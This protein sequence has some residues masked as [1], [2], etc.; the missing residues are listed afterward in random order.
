MKF[1]DLGR[2]KSVAI[3]LAAFMLLIG[4]VLG[5]NMYMSQLF[6]NDLSGV[7]YLSRQQVQPAVVV[8]NSHAIAARLKSHESIN[9]AFS[10]LRA[11]ATDIDQT[12]NSLANTATVTDEQGRMYSFSSMHDE[13]AAS[14]L[15][16][17]ARS[18]NSY[19]TK[20][21]VVLRLSGNPYDTD[22]SG[23]M[24]LNERGQRLAEALAAL[25]PFEE[26]VQKELSAAFKTV[27]EQLEA[28][29]KSRVGVLRLVQIAAIVIALGGLIAILSYLGGTLRS[30]EIQSGLA[31]KETTN[32][33]RTVNEGLFLLDRNQR[34]GSERSLAMA[35]IFRREDLDGMTFE[36]LLRNIVPEKTLKTAQDYVTLLWGE[37]VN[38][39][40][41]KTINPL[42]EVEVHFDNPAGG[43][44][45]H[46]L[47]FDFNRVKSDGQLTHLLVTVN[48][49]TKRVMLAR[50][51]QE[52]QEKAQAQL[53]LLLRI[54]HV[55][56][57]TLTGFLTDAET[58]LKMVNTI[59][60]EPAREE[61]VFRSKIDNI[62]R[63]IHAVKGE[64][65][66]LGLKTVEQRAHSFEESLSEIKSRTS[67]SGNDFLPLV[68]KLDDLFNH[69]AQ[70]REMLGR[71]VDLH[72]AIATRRASE[73]GTKTTQKTE[74][75]SEEVNDWLANANN[76]DPREGTSALESLMSGNGLK[77]TLDKLAQK[78][79]DNSAKQVELETTGLE[80]VPEAYRRAI[81][82]I[83]IQL[84]RNAVVHGIE[85]P[86]ERKGTNK[87]E[88][89]QLS[90]E[91]ADHGANGV[92]LT[93]KDDGRGLQLDR[94]KQ[95]AIERGLLSAGQAALLDQRQTMALI[96]R[97]GFSTADGVT[98]DA[99][100][101]A[102]M[103]LVR[104]VVAELNGRVGMSTAKGRYTKFK[105][106]LPPLSQA[107]VAA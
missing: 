47:E 51:L 19:K 91:F 34:I 26:K 21:D 71:L 60:R 7:K 67:I 57:S 4:L 99:G 25:T 16:S 49:V 76:D 96:F 77:R 78:V 6:S 72:Q 79:A 31:R 9:D 80:T 87:P 98:S 70:V 3:G 106:W 48:D 2:Y 55:D 23:V 102:G 88:F 14:T 17:A 10:D 33:L 39:K 66:A 64:S 83:T 42:N 73:T 18:W 74:V 27:S 59:L 54:L 61:S 1:L 65:S 63:Q 105:V 89:G 84:V 90:I 22:A 35:N 29:G 62:Y 12:L 24:T 46:F 94:I 56:P 28:N 30:E 5:F 86:A 15:Q 20:L 44:D 58:S 36:G 82:D 8:A 43:F 38:E 41:V 52:S 97:P 85:A 32:I 45:T 50:E 13:P 104:V 92:E 101:G 11:A 53:D 103:D 81:K 107:V 69:L 100:R 37:R 40:L 93:V 75:D 68:V 95:V